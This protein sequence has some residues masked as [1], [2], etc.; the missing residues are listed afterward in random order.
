MP[1][2]FVVSQA[3]HV[4]SVDD[5]WQAIHRPEFDPR[6]TVIL[7]GESRRLRAAS[8]HIGRLRSRT[9]RSMT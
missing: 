7:T 9:E 8:R 4:A 1:R 2:A 5:A 3:E 6:Q